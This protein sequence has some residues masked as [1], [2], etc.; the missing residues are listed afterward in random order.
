[1]RARSESQRPDG[2]DK[3]TSVSVACL[4]GAFEVLELGSSM[5][6]NENSMSTE[7]SDE[8]DLQKGT[9]KL[10][11]RIK[12]RGRTGG[13]SCTAVSRV[14]DWVVFVRDCCGEYTL[15]RDRKTFGIISTPRCSRLSLDVHI[16]VLTE[17]CAHRRTFFGQR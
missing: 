10:S 14:P 12:R 17:L 6:E 11:V 1:M 16:K 2:R 9:S 5:E 7:V 3:P 4:V 13:P 8:G 15:A